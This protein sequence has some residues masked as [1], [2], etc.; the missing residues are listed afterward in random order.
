LGDAKDTKKAMED[1]FGK[2]SSRGMQHS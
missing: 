1:E 2:I